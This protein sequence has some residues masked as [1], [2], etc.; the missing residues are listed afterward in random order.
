M[1]ICAKSSFWFSLSPCGAASL[2]ASEHWDGVT[3]H[4]L[5]HPNVCWALWV[6]CK[7]D[8][9]LN[10]LL[11]YVLLSKLV[12]GPCF[13]AVLLCWISFIPGF[14]C[15]SGGWWLTFR[16]G[17]PLCSIPWLMGMGT[18]A[19]ARSV[20]SGLF[21]IFVLSSERRI[22]HGCEESSYPGG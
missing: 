3:R 21:T 11:A 9:T 19:K 2:A 16:P 17:F 14:V 22:S 18:E 5:S 10:S 1:R 12:A 6:L 8:F 4:F 13:V 7:E 20:F 15:Q